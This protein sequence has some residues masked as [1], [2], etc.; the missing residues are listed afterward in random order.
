[1]GSTHLVWP[2]AALVGLI[3]SSGCKSKEEKAC[4]NFMRLESKTFKTEKDCLEA[5]KKGDSQCENPDEVLEC[6]ADA[7]DEKALEACGDKCKRKKKKGG[8]AT[9]PSGGGDAKAHCLARC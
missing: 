4:D 7:K 1:M 5:M 3:L 6:A 9:A 2:A 8:G